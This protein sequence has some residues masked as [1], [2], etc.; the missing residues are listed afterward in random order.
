MQVN[1]FTTPV[2]IDA[3]SLLDTRN[4]IK[5]KFNLLHVWSMA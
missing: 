2:P 1:K 5:F 4:K 3:R